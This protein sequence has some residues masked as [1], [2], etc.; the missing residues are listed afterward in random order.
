METVLVTGSSGLIGSAVIARLSSRYRVVGL[1][2]A[3]PRSS[4]NSYEHVNLDLTSDASVE[5]AM[6]GVQS[7]HGSRIAALIHLAAYY[8]LSGDPSPKYE[9]VTVQGTRRL[10][11]VLQGFELG[12]F[13]FASTMLVHAPTR[14][15]VPLHEGSPLG[16][17]GPYPQSKVRTERLIQDRRGHLPVTIIRPAGVYDEMCHSAFLSR[18]IANIFERQ[19]VSYVYPGDPRTGQACLHLD[20]LTDAIER[21]VDR[22][23]DLPPS[24]DLLLGESR[25]ASY[26]DLQTDIGCLIHGEAW[27]TRRV[28]KA[29]ALAGQWLQE[30]VLDDDPFVQPWMIEQAGDHYE[31]DISRAQNT[32]GWRPRHFVRDVLPVMIERLK[33]DPPGWYRANRLEASKVAADEAV[34]KKSRER[35]AADLPATIEQAAEERT[36]HHRRTLWAHFANMALGAWLV[37]SPFAF[38]LFDAG[39][40]ASIP[41]AAGHALAAADVR[42]T[43]LG[44][45]EGASGIAVIALSILGLPERNA[46]LRWWTAAI[47]VWILFAPLAFWTTSAAAYAS[48]TLVGTLMIVFA[49]MVPPQPGIAR[50]AMASRA[51]IPLG[52]TYSPSSYVQR[53]P[54]V[55]L[56]CIGFFVSRYLAAYQL[57][58]ID[59]AWDPFFK[60][61]PDA[62]NGTEEVVTS[63]VSKAFPIPDA[64]FGALAYILDVLT[65][66][67]ADQRRWRT[68]PWLVLVFGLLVIPLGLVSVGFIIIQ[69]TVIGALCA[70]C[71]IQA[72]ITL[73]MIPY[74]LDEV[75]ATAQYLWRSKRA[76]FDLWRTL[77]RGGPGLSEDRDRFD[78]L[79]IPVRAMIRDFIHG[80]VTYPWTLMASAALGLLLIAKPL[81]VEVAPPLSHSDHVVGCLVVAVAITAMAECARMTRLLNVPLALW[82]IASPFA[83]DATTEALVFNVSVGVVLAWFSLPRGRL[84][85]SHYGGWDRYIV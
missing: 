16:P 37:S 77:W 15:G 33:A 43:W 76:G 70:L 7:A 46:F 6:A 52:W 73:A 66:V 5:A 26:E 19:L 21:I 32:I 50:A 25:T 85:G 4:N 28:P 40:D 80:G 57:G 51:D 1:D 44:I 3:P 67:I 38:G 35:L 10:L 42:N 9:T 2:L 71:L 72:L 64:G 48:D 55:V 8:D 65:G 13:V 74:S 12:R 84:S 34:L 23:N 75:L 24:L 11:D 79:D 54:I 56:A 45:S 30:D 27:N 49:V 41:P 59:S 61:G 69:P 58:H 36:A 39:A 81:I 31:L 17:K 78:H 53:V 63:S 14:P 82:L 18:Q 60:G 22:R 83:M 47:G 29:L 62:K 20:D 68:M